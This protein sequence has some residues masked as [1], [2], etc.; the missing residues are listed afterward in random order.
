MPNNTN[1]HQAWRS[2]GN[3]IG[4]VEAINNTGTGDKYSYTDKVDN[5][6]LM[7]EHQCKAFC[8]YMK[9]CATVGFWG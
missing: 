8:A 4:Y 2:I 7:S 5:A 1:I 6:L 9:Q 3:G